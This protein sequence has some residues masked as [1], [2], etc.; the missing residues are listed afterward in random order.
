MPERNRPT[1][2]GLQD[3]AAGESSRRKARFEELIRGVAAAPPLPIPA[4]HDPPPTRID[5][6]EVLDRLGEGGMG[7]VY[8][9]RDERLDRKVAIKVVHP[10]LAGDLAAERLLREARA[11]A[12]L[13]HP[14]VVPIHE[15]GNWND[16]VFLVME[17]VD[18][19]TLRDWVLRQ[20]PSIGAILSAYAQATRGLQAAHTAGLIH[21]DFKP[22]NALLG[23]DGRVRVADF[24][25]VGAIGDIRNTPAE[26]PSTTEADSGEH[27]VPQRLTR[28]GRVMGTPAYMAPEQLAGKAPNAR[29]DQY[30]LCVS[31]W[32]SVYGRRPFEANE[33]GPKPSSDWARPAGKQEQRRV[34]PP[35]PPPNDDV[36]EGLVPLL[37]RGLSFDPGA[38]F[39]SLSLVLDELEKMSE[40]RSGTSNTIAT[41]SDSERALLD[42]RFELLDS[43]P[44]SRKANAPGSGANLRNAY[45]RLKR[46]TIVLR[47]LTSD[48]QTSPGIAGWTESWTAIC[49][50]RHPNIAAVEE[51]GVA[52]DGRIYCALDLPD[53]S[54]TIEQAAQ[55]QPRGIVLNWISQILQALVY[56][57]RQGVGHLRLCANTVHVVGGQVRLLDCGVSALFHDPI[58]GVDAAGKFA[59]PEL[60]AKLLGDHRADLFSVGRI[61]STLLLEPMPSDNDDADTVK[62]REVVARMC[63]TEPS[64]RCANAREAIEAIGQATG[65]AFSSETTETRESFLQASSFVGRQIELDEIRIRITTATTMGKHAQILIGGE[66][67]AGKSRM[68]REVAI[69]ARSQGATVIYG[70]ARREAARPFELWHNVFSWLTLSGAATDL[71]RDVFAEVTPSLVTTDAR[72]EV[73]GESIGPQ[74]IENRL[75]KTLW[76]SLSKLDRPLVVVLEDLQW[77]GEDSLELIAELATELETPSPDRAPSLPI[78]VVGTYRSDDAPELAARLPAAYKVQ[79]NRL[80]TP[81]MREMVTSIVGPLRE[82]SD[83]I[84]WLWKET[85]GNV[86][87][88]VEILRAL[89]EQAGT[90]DLIASM[91]LPEKLFVGGISQILRRRLDRVG[92]GVRKTLD[93]VAV[94]GREVDTEILKRFGEENVNEWLD[95]C[96]RAAILEQAGGKWRFVHD[97]LRETVLSQIEPDRRRLMH[98]ET[99]RII[100]KHDTSPRRWPELAYHFRQAEI[101]D[102]E[103]VYASYASEL[104]LRSGAYHEAAGFAERAVELATQTTLSPR[105]RMRNL[106]MLGQS[107]FS[108]GRLADANLRYSDALGIVR[109]RL[110]QGRLGWFWLLGR[111]FSRFFLR[112]FLPASMRHSGSKKKQ[113]KRNIYAEA[114]L[115]AS[116]MWYGSMFEGD[117]TRNAALAFLSANLAERAEEQNVLA[118]GILGYL[119]RL[120][121]LERMATKYFHRARIETDKNHGN[122]DAAMAAQIQAVSV[123]AVGRPEET[124]EITAWGSQHARESSDAIA[125]ATLGCLDAAVEFYRGH[126]EESLALYRKHIQSIRAFPDH[127]RMMSAGEIYN[128]CML[129]R[130]SE[131]QARLDAVQTGR[132]EK[133]YLLGRTLTV[134]NQAL[135]HLWSGR[136]TAARKACNELLDLVL[137]QHVDIPAVCSQVPLVLSEIAIS[138]EKTGHDVTLKE[139]HAFASRVKT[140]VSGWIRVTPS[141]KP[142]AQIFEG[143]RRSIAGNPDGAR[144]LFDAALLEAHRTGQPMFAAMADFEAGRANPDRL[145]LDRLRRARGQ[146]ATMGCTIHVGWIDALLEGPGLGGN[147]YN[148]T[149]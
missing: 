14:N 72:S 44:G 81:E 144:K 129:G 9:A 107:Y 36:P 69:F 8:L 29:S 118:F 101:P 117:G 96:R 112:Q 63:A 10:N 34:D 134:A 48:A 17:Y 6:Y 86:L 136:I 11:L 25:I 79:L 113:K 60:K 102:R 111:E 54:Q 77:A 41:S 148:K 26:L 139:T 20:R 88:V 85:E 67:G 145:D 78:V 80:S 125:L 15:V 147:L 128:L 138:V 45:D 98:A 62:L 5:R 132:P 13:S 127:V 38:R 92:S 109:L 33:Q 2:N 31:I 123:I 40:V 61:L 65:R 133:G 55:S 110:P 95:E 94:I 50:L 16:R 82:R 99:A 18:G 84:D 74:T 122:A 137:D 106:R 130:L 57:H 140:A 93:R 120:I 90:L 141:G 105:R 56:L 58:A 28:T 35:I 126:F 4:R 49:S 53:G 32:E 30:S 73:R 70:Q 66:S 59:A 46:R 103:A 75:K 7:V 37:V 119:S 87:F 1:K 24:G 131:A 64:S 19:W 3:G 42:H 104:A 149:R 27:S 91:P 68:A 89:G 12:R 23:R 51:F 83:I 135:I 116:R 76:E 22:E 71:D 47:M 100:E 143:K 21:R 52:P 124:A 146:F 114:S 121:G 142:L 39:P 108:L 97:K 43:T 115:T